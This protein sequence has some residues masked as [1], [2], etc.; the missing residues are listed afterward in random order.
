MTSQAHD[1]QIFVARAKPGNV[2]AKLKRALGDDT[3]E[4]AAKKQK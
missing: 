3:S 2:K 1:L 4:Q